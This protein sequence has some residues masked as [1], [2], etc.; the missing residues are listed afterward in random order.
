MIGVCMKRKVLAFC[1]STV[2]LCPSIAAVNP[3]SA[4]AEECQGVTESR[5]MASDFDNK[6]H[7][8]ETKLNSCD[9]Q[10]A[11]DQLH[12]AGGAAAL[13]GLIGVAVPSIGAAS[14]MIG[15]W[16]WQNQDAFR[17]C[18]EAGRG[19]SFKEVNGA[20]MDCHPQ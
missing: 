17:G 4:E 20:V 5:H 14:A 15:V 18:A 9:T 6:M 2:A 7:W 19:V 3:A 13:G 8:Y 1:V 12:V 16:A 10:K 11:L